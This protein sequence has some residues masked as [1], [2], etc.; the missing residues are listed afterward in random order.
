MSY[1]IHLD[2]EAKGPFT[3]GQL[4]SMWRSGAI[5]GDTLYC[6][7]GYEEWLHLRVLADE[8]E[9]V[10]QPP[11][12]PRSPPP[13]IVPNRRSTARKTLAVV[14]LT[15][16]GTILV[17][18]LLVSLAGNP[19]SQDATEPMAA[20]GIES[21]PPI[22]VRLNE[23]L[24]TVLKMTDQLD[25]LYKRGCSSTEFVA[26]GSPAESATL[27]LE[28]QLPK[29]DP[30]RDLL[31]N[32]FEGYQKVA[33]EM[34]RKEQGSGTESLDALIAVAG[35]RKVL[36]TKILEGHMTPSEKNVYYVWRKSLTE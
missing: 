9:E 34:R 33:F 22:T 5:T 27:K 36:L 35:V 18:W 21:L 12:I 25:A 20:S 23:E 6:A 15:I 32:T 8:L 31:V 13:L 4:R 24:L 19:S 3:I 17:L 16:F 7:E 14:S 10:Q 26:A 2:D 30:R 1:F 11:P 28:S 29:D